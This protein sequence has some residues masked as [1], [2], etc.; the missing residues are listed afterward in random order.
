MPAKRND[1]KHNRIDGAQPSGKGLNVF[2]YAF[3]PLVFVAVI[4]FASLVSHLEFEHLSRVQAEQAAL[5]HRYRKRM[6]LCR[7]KW[8]LKGHNYE[9]CVYR[10]IH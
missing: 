8:P 6:E 5:E 10:I 9:S 1:I 3:L 7:Q 2:V 4:S